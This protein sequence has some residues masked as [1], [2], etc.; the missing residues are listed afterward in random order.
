MGVSALHFGV[1]MCVN[2]AIGQATPPVGVNLF[3]A[4]GL[5]KVSLDRISRAVLPFIL[6]EVGAL[7][8]I[9]YVPALSE[10]LPTLL[11]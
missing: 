8:V 9:S 10:W 2:L 6:A 1:I 5:S 4:C 7:L 11:R 3:V